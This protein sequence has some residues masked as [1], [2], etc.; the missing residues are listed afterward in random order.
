[1]G[2][3]NQIHLVIIDCLPEALTDNVA[4]FVYRHELADRQLADRNQQ[5]GLQQGKLVFHPWLAV[6]NLLWCRNPV[7]ALVLFAGKAA[8]HRCHVDPLPECFLVQPDLRKPAEQG[9]A[10]SPGERPV[11]NDFTGAGRLADQHDR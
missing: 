4:Q 2:Q 11:L 3:G 6:G 1:M 10:G 9:F 7:P 5:S 8:A